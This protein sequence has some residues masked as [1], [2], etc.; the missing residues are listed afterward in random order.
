MANAAEGTNRVIEFLRG[1][2]AL[3]HWKR[4]SIVIHLHLRLARDS[5][6]DS[7]DAGVLLIE[8]A[9]LDVSL[10]LWIILLR[11]NFAD[12]IG[13]FVDTLLLGCAQVSTR[14]RA[15]GLLKLSSR[16]SRSLLPSLAK[17]IPIFSAEVTLIMRSL[18]PWD[19]GT[20]A[21]RCGLHRSVN[22]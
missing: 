7:P 17:V 16:V 6:V 15:L 8:P 13:D 2:N 19:D 22:E 10:L 18:V 21:L 20:E 5:I 12:E 4:V 3:A 14:Q 11:V 1:V 9:A